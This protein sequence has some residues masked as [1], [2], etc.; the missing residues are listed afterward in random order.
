MNTESC[1]APAG[2]P[3]NIA[4]YAALTHLMAHITNHRAT[5]LI[6]N[7]GDDHIYED[8]LA[9]LPEQLMR[10]PISL[11]SATIK[12]PAYVNELSDFIQLNAEE[13]AGL[14]QGYEEGTYHPRLDY[15]VAV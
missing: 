12:Y 2:K 10:A 5:K 14:I 7:V 4:Q 11:P 15:P 1:D 13:L 6:V 3:F 8:Q 9:L